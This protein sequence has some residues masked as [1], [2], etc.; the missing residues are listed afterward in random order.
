RLH[1]IVLETARQQF[2]CRYFSTIRSLGVGRVADSPNKAT[3][4]PARRSLWR[5][6]PNFCTLIE[7]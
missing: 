4:I 3:G 6:T 2:F 5:V 7:E 1:S